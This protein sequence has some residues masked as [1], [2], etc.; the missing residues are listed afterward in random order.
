[1][2]RLILLW[3]LLSGSVVSATAQQPALVPYMPGLITDDKGHE[4]YIEQN[5]TLQRNSN[6]PSMIGNCMVLQFGGQ[7]F[8]SQQPMMSPDGKEISMSS[9]QPFGGV[10]ITRRVT[11]MEREGV[12]RCVDEFFNTT[13]RDLTV[14]LE[15]RHGLNNT[16]REVASNLGRPI[17]DALEDEEFG[18]LALP[19][20]GEGNPPALF[21]SIRAPKS[22]A[23]VKLRIHNKYQISILHTLT[24]PAGQTQSIIH[25]VA[26]I[27]I[28]AKAKP[29]DIAKACAPMALSRLIKGLPKSVIKMAVN[30]GAPSGGFGLAEWLP[31]EYWGITPA[32]SDQLALGNDS[33]LKGRGVLNRL[34]LLRE[35]GPAFANLESVAAI[36]GPGFA[37]GGG[38][39]IWLRDGQRWR[40]TLEIPDLRFIL[41]SGAELPV[42]QLDRLVLAKASQQP[43]A[44]LAVTMLEFWSG[45]RIAIEPESDL[46][47]STLWGRLSVPWSEV[48]AWQKP[49]EQALG[50]LLCLR[51]GTRLRAL[52]Q[53]G[54]MKLKTKSLGEQE[55]DLADMRRLITPL[56]TTASDDDLEPSTSFLEL[57]GEQRVVA[58]VTAATLTLLTQGGPLSL[59]P[60]NI[61]ELRDVTE[62][63]GSAVRIFEADLWGGGL[64]RGMLENARV[65]AEGRGL[66]WDI[67]TRQILRMSNPVPVTDHALMRRI[68]QLIQDLGH[69]QWKTREAASTAL[70]E[71][72]PL[73]RGSLQEALKSAT[74]AE[75]VR[76]LEELMQDQE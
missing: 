67:S 48:I 24:I 33:L 38:S 22:T 52:P 9:Q 14:T 65:H 47:A 66:S 51:D 27:D 1:M 40:G 21:F 56:A 3:L 57:A 46:Q 37:E 36:A 42:I 41:N 72:G 6:G 18:V 28:A 73:A 63:E 49:E 35:G 16:A 75:V 64:V 54:K 13:K 34:G 11:I 23:P 76:R 43:A 45:E 74:D 60:G 71:L 30:L 44:S 62:N 61:R 58:R 10:S 15:M 5:G 19:Q 29:E 70:R 32:N 2:M 17:K 68:G 59:S 26:Q 12:L 69:E 39:W 55:L 25:A 8:Y 31:R 53:A 20:E 7:Q 4:W 50:G